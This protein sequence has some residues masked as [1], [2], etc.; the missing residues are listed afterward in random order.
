MADGETPKKL[1]FRQLLPIVTFGP[2]VCVL[3]PTAAAGGGT[4]VGR[5]AALVHV[6]GAIS[7]SAI[8]GGTDGMQMRISNNR[9]RRNGEKFTQ[10]PALIVQTGALRI[11]VPGNLAVMAR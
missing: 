11:R 7:A 4:W 1:N 9:F 10:L 8:M 6:P 3:K 5:S 2:N